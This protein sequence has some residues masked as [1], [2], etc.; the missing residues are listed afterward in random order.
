MLGPKL[1]ADTLGSRLLAAIYDGENTAVR[2]ALLDEFG[3]QN[4]HKWARRHRRPH[5]DARP[6]LQRIAGI[7]VEAWTTP[8]GGAS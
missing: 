2:L 3:S 6:A 8:A 4:L 5:G 1:V 7:A